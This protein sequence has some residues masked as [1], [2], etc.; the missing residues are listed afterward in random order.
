[1]R[2]RIYGSGGL[3]ALPPI[4]YHPMAPQGPP[5]ARQ[6][7]PP[8]S[9]VTSGRG[10]PVPSEYRNDD[11]V[12]S[13]K[14]KSPSPPVSLEP[15]PPVTPPWF[16]DY[17]DY[18]FD[19]RDPTSGENLEVPRR[20][21]RPFP[22]P[23]APGQIFQPTKPGVVP[24]FICFG[25]GYEDNRPTFQLPFGVSPPTPSRPLPDVPLPAP[26]NMSPLPRCLGRTR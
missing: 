25:Q 15:T 6:Q 23:K 16:V 12:L 9:P 11:E 7:P 26:G 19:Y 13:Y 17:W 18:D 3:P 1:M 14:L 2:M 8:P 10:S 21:P 5:A 22:T 24:G 20:V 4:P